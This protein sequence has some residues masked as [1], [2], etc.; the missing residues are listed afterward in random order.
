M[1]KIS[2]REAL[3]TTTMFLCDSKIE[4]Y[5][6]NLL[7]S[8]VIAL[9]QKLLGIGTMEGLTKYIRSEQKSIDNILIS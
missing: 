1:S 6:E 4:A 7:N 8:Q 9:K 3:R 5:Y 2:H